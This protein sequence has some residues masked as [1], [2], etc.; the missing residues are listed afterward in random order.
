MTR[1][2]GIQTVHCYYFNIVKEISAI[3]A[4]KFDAPTVIDL[5]Y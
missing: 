3:L 5:Y 1:T 4:R 2:D